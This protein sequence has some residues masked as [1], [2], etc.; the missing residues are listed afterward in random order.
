MPK[1]YG[2]E[3]TME[4]EN[5][6]TG[7]MPKTVCIKCQVPFIID[8]NEVA[9]H[10]F[11]G[12]GYYYSVWADRWRC[13]ECGTEILS[14]FA[15]QPFSVNYMTNGIKPIITWRDILKAKKD[16]MEIDVKL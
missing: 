4:T 7:Y 15:N 5:R 1:S 11:S 16:R 10:A 2:K 8:R 14:G 3:S 6:F 9:M 13:P 12:K